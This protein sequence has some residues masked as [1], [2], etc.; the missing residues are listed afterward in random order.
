MHDVSG[1]AGFAWSFT[2][3]LVEAFKDDDYKCKNNHSA[4]KFRLADV[5][6]NR[7]SISNDDWN[8]QVISLNNVDN[9]DWAEEDNKV[10]VDVQLYSTLTNGEMCVFDYEVHFVNPLTIEC[11]P[12]TLASNNVT[13]KAN[14]NEYVVVKFGDITLFEDGAWTA[15][16]TGLGLDAAGVSVSTFEAVVPKSVE[17]TV[18]KGTLA[19]DGTMISWNNNGTSLTFDETRVQYKIVNTTKNIGKTTQFG[20]VTLL[21]TK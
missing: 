10:E 17:E 1:A 15:A 6:E 14:L 21:K 13:S 2:E 18:N 4:L 8:K 11:L 20:K 9:L 12:V 16:A 5:N 19:V 3:T 7:V